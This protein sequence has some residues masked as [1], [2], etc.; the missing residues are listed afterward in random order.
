M[1]KEKTS[2]RDVFMH[3]L[4]IITLYI[5]AGSF[6]ALLFQYINVLWPDQLQGYYE[7]R[8]AYSAI[9]WAIAA[10]V[11]TY[12]VHLWIMW[13]L[14]KSYLA[15]PS[16]RNLRIRKWLIYFTLFAAGLI[17]MGDAVALIYNL[18]SG[19][20]TIRFLL[21]VL[22]VFLVAGTVFGYYLRDVRRH[23]TE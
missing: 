23:K 13:S 22:S 10:L 14:N 3:L 18:L 8:S 16:K 4:S 5:S 17:L 19:E 21:K 11:V 9:R 6:L 2:P 7:A 1:E 15:A 12:P 20:L